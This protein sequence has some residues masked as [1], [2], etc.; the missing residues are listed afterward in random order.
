MD[1]ILRAIKKWNK[2]DIMDLHTNLVKLSVMSEGGLS[3]VIDPSDVPTC[4]LPSWASLVGVWAMDEKDRVLIEAGK[5][6][7]RVVK[8]DELPVPKGLMLTEHKTLG[9]K[10]EVPFS[11]RLTQRMKDLIEEA[12]KE[13][14]VSAGSWVRETIA[15]RLI[16][17]G[18]VDE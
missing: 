5:G 10:G 9:G 16:D 7:W 17:E 8:K 2:Q 3:K 12:A 13:R 18:Y 14:E 15:T 6:K 1:K 11:F 4:P